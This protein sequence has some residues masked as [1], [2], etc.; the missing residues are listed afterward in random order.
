MA[1]RFDIFR[2]D[3]F[4]QMKEENTVQ[5]TEFRSYHYRHGV[6]GALILIGIGLI[7][8]L[9]N[10]GLLPL[11]IWQNLWRFWPAILILAGLQMV[12][13]RSRGAN[14]IVLLVGLLFIALIILLSMAPGNPQV[15]S[16][17]NQ[18]LPGFMNQNTFRHMDQQ[19]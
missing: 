16:W 8:L 1:A 11:D 12:I 18:Y 10:L 3:Y 5:Q 13:G 15:N 14:I 17:F 4:S 19:Y 7:L 6:V 2:P 9:Y